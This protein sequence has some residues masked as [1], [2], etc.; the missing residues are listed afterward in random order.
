MGTP[1]NSCGTV[2][3]SG[4]GYCACC[5]HRAVLSP[6]W[7]HPN[8]RVC[9]TCRTLLLH[10]EGNGTLTDIAYAFHLRIQ[11]GDL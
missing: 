1:D 11:A 5:H 2:G 3:T 4:L 10:M 9:C 7:D 8:I 6:H